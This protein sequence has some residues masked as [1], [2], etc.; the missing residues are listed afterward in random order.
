ME[1]GIDLEQLSKIK[2]QLES[3]QSVARNF[4]NESYQ[5]YQLYNSEHSHT[6]LIQSLI[7]IHRTVTPFR[8]R[9]APVS[10]STSSSTTTAT[11]P[12]SSATPKISHLSFKNTAKSY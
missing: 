7:D 8:P 9:A 10:L 11:P 3:S 4:A 2:A 5:E 12:A 1:K 6:D